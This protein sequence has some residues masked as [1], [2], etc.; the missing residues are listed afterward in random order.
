M[1]FVLYCR[2]DGKCPNRRGKRKSKTEPRSMEQ[3]ETLASPSETLELSLE[4]LQRA[5]LSELHYG[6]STECST[7]ARN[8]KSTI[9]L[10]DSQ[11]MESH[12]REYSIP[13]HSRHTIE[14][15]TEQ[16]VVRSLTDLFEETNAQVIQHLFVNKISTDSFRIW[17]LLVL[18]KIR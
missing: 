7:F 5:E 14:N 8:K 1:S 6:T 13:R 18:R 11:N 2:K 15:T 3:P 4:T 16:V 10:A 9:T 17:K 12:L